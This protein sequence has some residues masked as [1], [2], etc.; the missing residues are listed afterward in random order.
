MTE[1]ALNYRQVRVSFRKQVSDGNYGTE[2]AEMTMED[3]VHPDAEA[4][5][6]TSIAELMLRTCRSLVH[7]ELARSPSTKVRAALG[8]PTAV[9]LGPSDYD[10]EGDEMPIW[11]RP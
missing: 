6:D 10:D 8:K 4:N 3:Y 7:E 11:T 9:T 1:H 2:A 5:V